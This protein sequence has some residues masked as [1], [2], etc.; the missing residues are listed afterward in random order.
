MKIH[1]K[2]SVFFIVSICMVA[3]CTTDK[4]SVS[5][6]SMNPVKKAE[7]TEI[8]VSAAASLQNGLKEFA[9]HFEKLHPEI[10]L[11]FNFAASG[12]L[13]QQIEQGAPSDLFIS[14]GQKQMDALSAKQLILEDKSVPLLTNS[15]VVI[16]PN[17][18]K[19]SI[20][21][22]ADLTQPNLQKIALGDTESVPAGTYTKETLSYYKLWQQ[23]QPKLVFA[24]DVRQVLTYV[25]SANVDAGFVYQTDALTSDKVK[26]VYTADSASHKA[27][28][29][30]V[31]V[32]KATK[33]QNEASLLWSE[34]Q[35]KETAD[36]FNKYGFTKPGE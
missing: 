23:L 2:I 16:V 29:Y 11:T 3:G 36:I 30:P 6:S 35:S 27:I 10:K 13:Q 12:A 7:Q 4:S 5:M 28:T 21:N 34:L 22:A 1:W 17:E 8:I 31:A 15:L 26:I 20:T 19:L 9:A 14:A 32:V 24:K 25:E 33:H 18:S